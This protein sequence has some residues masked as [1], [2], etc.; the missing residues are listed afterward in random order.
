MNK[1]ETDRNPF[2]GLPDIGVMR[3]KDVFKALGIADSTGYL[4]LAQGRLPKTISIGPNTRAI[5]NSQLKAWGAKL[6]GQE[7]V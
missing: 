2:A 1:A 4:W 3:I 5:T 7:A 6:V